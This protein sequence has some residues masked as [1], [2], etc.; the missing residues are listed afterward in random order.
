MG[1]N[2]FFALNTIKNL[3]IF[4][5]NDFFLSPLTKKYFYFYKFYSFSSKTKL[6]FSKK[7]K[8]FQK[9]YQIINLWNFFPFI[10]L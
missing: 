10:F 1:L 8:N 6:F 2:H 3:L 4:Y 9:K 5:F 7:K